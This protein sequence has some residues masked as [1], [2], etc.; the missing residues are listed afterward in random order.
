MRIDGALPAHISVVQRERNLARLAA[1]QQ[2]AGRFPDEF[3]VGQVLSALAPAA[4]ELSLAAAARIEADRAAVDRIWAQRVERAAIACDLARRCYQLAEPENRLVM[5]QLERDWEEALAAQAQLAEDHRRHLATL[6]TRLTASELA[7]IR[8]LATDIP[9]IWTCATTTDADRKKL[10]HAVVESVTVQAQGTSERVRAVMHWAGSATTSADLI[11]PVARVDQ[12]SYYPRLVERITALATGTRQ[13]VL[14]RQHP[15]ERVATGCP[16]RTSATRWAPVI[17]RQRAVRGQDTSAAQV[18]AFDLGSAVRCGGTQPC[19]SVRLTDAASFIAS[20]NKIF[21]IVKISRAA[22]ARSRPRPT[23][24][25]VSCRALGH[26]SNLGRWHARTRPG[27]SSSH[28]GRVRSCNRVICGVRYRMPRWS[29]RLST[30]S[31]MP[32]P[33]V[34]QDVAINM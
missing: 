3:V 6:P 5:R 26:P 9:A 32:M 27:R 33:T 25:A 31:P 15:T 23:H 1:N 21:K 4:V 24:D 8:A 28:S 19:A 18:R 10:L 20:W 14:L 34:A 2:M 12:L 29:S 7:T 30:A 13:E 16:A 11:R 22:N 17:V